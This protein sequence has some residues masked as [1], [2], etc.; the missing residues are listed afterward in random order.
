MA[1]P[2]TPCFLSLWTVPSV[3]DY[4]STLGDEVS[5]ITL[6]DDCHNAPS[7]L[8]P[9]VFKYFKSAQQLYRLL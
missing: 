8:R 4:I 1:F 6:R 3:E 5:R 2:F 9:L 7:L